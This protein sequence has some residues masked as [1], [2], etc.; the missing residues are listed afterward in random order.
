MILQERRALRK[1]QEGNAAPP[2]DADLAPARAALGTLRSTKHRALRPRQAPGGAG[3]V[4]RPKRKGIFGPGNEPSKQSGGT[5]GRTPA[6]QLVFVS[7]I[8]HPLSFPVQR[9]HA[10]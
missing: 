10:Q 3:G 7:V 1:A 8:L 2:E 9:V 4:A 6:Q 5:H